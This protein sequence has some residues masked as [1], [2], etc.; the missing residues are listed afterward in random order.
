[1]GGLLYL[2]FIIKN[3]LPGSPGPQAQKCSRLLG[4]R[5]KE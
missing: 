1:M 2:Y 4:Q 3:G 5:L